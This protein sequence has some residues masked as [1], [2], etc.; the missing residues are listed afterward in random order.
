MICGFEQ[1]LDEVGCRAEFGTLPSEGEKCGKPECVGG[2]Q[3]FKVE[4]D[5]SPGLTRDSEEFARL[6]FAIDPSVDADNG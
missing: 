1:E 6:D 5:W 4:D 2:P 3:L